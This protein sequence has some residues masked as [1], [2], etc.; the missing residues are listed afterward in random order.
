[1]FLFYHS[2]QRILKVHFGEIGHLNTL[3]SQYTMA[4]ELSQ[5]QA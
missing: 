3:A 5:P 2:F 1:M 4:S